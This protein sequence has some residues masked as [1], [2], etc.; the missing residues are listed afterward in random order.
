MPLWAAVAI[1]AAAYV[2][3]SVSRG[4]DFRP[5]LPSDLLAF[6]L[7]AAVF[8][9]VAIARRASPPSRDG[10]DALSGEVSQKHDRTGD[11]R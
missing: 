4:F 5:D 1:P 11:P 6:A 9:V 3:R 2:I 10:Q 7:F 8:A